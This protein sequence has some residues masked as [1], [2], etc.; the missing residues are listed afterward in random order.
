MSSPRWASTRSGTGTG[1]G[2]F[3]WV[4]PTVRTGGNAEVYY[5]NAHNEYLEALV[6]GGVIRLGLTLLL[7]AGTLVA[8]G[9]G[10][11]RRRDRSAPAR[12]GS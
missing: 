11:L 10:F 6:E 3:V 7:A 5:E 1:S 12:C 8:V 9:R 4:E 2:T